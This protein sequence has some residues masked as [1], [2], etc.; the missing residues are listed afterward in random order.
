MSADK[1]ET[2]LAL[3]DNYVVAYVLTESGFFQ[4]CYAVPTD[5]GVAAGVH[6]GRPLFIARPERDSPAPPSAK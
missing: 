1:C 2:H 6:K 5:L 4:K 3:T